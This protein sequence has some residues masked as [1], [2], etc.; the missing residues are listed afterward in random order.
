MSG[1]MSR[2]IV[3]TAS[4]LSNFAIL[5][6]SPLLL[7]RILDVQGYGKYQEFMIYATLFVTI[8]GFGI[9]ASLT[10]FLPRYPNQERQLVSQNSALIMVF[11]SVCLC[12]FLI[13]RKPFL[14]IASYDFTLPLAAYVFCFVNLNWLEY[15]WIAKRRTDLVLYYSAGRLF[16]RG[17]G[18]SRG[19]VFDS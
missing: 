15:Y 4:R 17:H 14:E 5:V 13:A 16:V 7:V 8:C 11:S 9:D 2:G 12:L 6:L 10:Y 3:L 18:A 19:G 1:L